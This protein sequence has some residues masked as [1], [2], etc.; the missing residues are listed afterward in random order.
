MY[1][2]KIW[3]EG[4]FDP[5]SRIENTQEHELGH[6]LTAFAVF[7]VKRDGGNKLTQNT[8]IK[9]LL[10]IPAWE[11]IAN[12]LC[13]RLLYTMKEEKW[14]SNPQSSWF[15]DFD[16]SQDETMMAVSIRNQNNSLVNELLWGLLLRVWQGEETETISWN[17]TKGK[18][19]AKALLL[20]FHQ[21][22][23]DPPVDETDGWLLRQVFGQNNF[24]WEKAMSYFQNLTPAQINHLLVPMREEKGGDSVADYLT[25]EL[26]E[27]ISRWDPFG[28]SISLLSPD[29]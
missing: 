27:K 20:K 28:S 3:E 29:G 11:S 21:M 2:S 19:A 6:L 9:Q 16:L 22:K 7:Q 26:D 13:N 8:T 15:D 17:R 18:A 1:G 5:K 4:Y 12:L 24:K 23:I 25:K 10:S 14:S